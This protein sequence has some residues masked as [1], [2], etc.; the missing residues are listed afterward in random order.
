MAEKRWF[1]LLWP[2]LSNRSARTDCQNFLKF[3]MNVDQL[4]LNRK[5]TLPLLLKINKTCRKS[6]SKR[7]YFSGD[8]LRRPGAISSEPVVKKSWIFYQRCTTIRSTSYQKIS[9]IVWSFFEK[10]PKKLEKRLF[11][12]FTGQYVRTKI[13]NQKSGSVIFLILRFFITM[14]NFSQICS[15]NLSNFKTHTLTDTLFFEI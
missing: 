5:Y 1:L 4:I 15:A 12:V 14:P 11:P 10:I 9:K 8:F 6:G 7:V 2:S 13:K 3:G